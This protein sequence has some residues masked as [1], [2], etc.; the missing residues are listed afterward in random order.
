MPDSTLTPEQ[1]QALLTSL[2]DTGK[3]PPAKL[4]DLE[5]VRDPT[6]QQPIA[7]RD[8]ATGNTITIPQPSASRGAPLAQLQR[9]DAQGKVI[10]ADDT[11]TQAVKLVDPN[12]SQNAIDLPNPKTNAQPSGEFKPIADPRDPSKT[13]GMVDTG[14]NSF[15]ALTTT[16]NNNQVLQTATGVY[17]FDP[18]QKDPSKALNLLTTIDK[19][20]P[21]QVVHLA[22]G[23]AMFD[24]NEK[25]PSKALTPLPQGAPQ[26]IKDAEGNTLLLQPDGSY[27][28][29]PGVTAKQPA[30][31]VSTNTQA[32][33]LIG[34]DDQGKVV[35]RE[36]NPNFVPPTPTQM[37]PDLVAPNIPLLKPDGTVQWVPNQN[38]V[39]AGQAMQ[40]LLGQV[41]VSVNGN[42]MSMADAKDM[43][44][45]A[46]NAMNA[47]TS[48][49]NAQTSQQQAAN[50]QQ[51]NI[52]SAANDILTN[53]RGN[54]Q[55][56]AGML[57]NRVTSATGALQSIIGSVAGSKI[58][59]IPSDFGA[60]LV[61]GL[62]SWVTGL[63]GGDATY[64]TAAR[65]VQ[66]AD[67]KISQDPTLANQAQ[68]TLAAMLQQYQ[69]QIGEPHPLVQA[70]LAAQQ[71]Q[72][73]NGMVAPNTSGTAYGQQTNAGVNQALQQQQQLA[74][75]QAGVAGQPSTAALNARGLM[76]TPQGRAIAA[77][78]TPVA[79]VPPI[80]PGQYNPAWQQGIVSPVGTISTGPNAA[81]GFI[82]PLIPV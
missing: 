55:T 7:Y 30:V 1:T 53:T 5:L 25:D 72:Q 43:L 67:P 59:N 63:G 61:G 17:S 54:A 34:L 20:S 76:D 48:R 6:T 8:P 73:Q 38:R 24:P 39:P 14:D 2:L 44:T 69:K 57:Q 40:D 74:A 11:T 46:A 33:E 78:Q 22:N 13:V 41:G 42:Q 28:V 68:T 16:Q 51:Q 4:G 66:A 23:D 18:T 15:H 3:T 70:T 77:G 82:A 10:P 45:G 21:M 58:Q 52:A 71:S 36:T 31:A 65:M 75:Q 9:I 29:P 49:M 35:S 56:G 60:N 27:K 81:N 26:T 32:R 62:T 12:N 79:A 37:T 19:S 80:Y 47:Q 64:D 50:Q